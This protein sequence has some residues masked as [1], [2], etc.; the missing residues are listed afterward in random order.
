MKE[1]EIMTRMEMI[2]GLDFISPNP[3]PKWLMILEVLFYFTIAIFGL[4]FNSAVLYALRK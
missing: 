1:M 2:I 4:V 3:R